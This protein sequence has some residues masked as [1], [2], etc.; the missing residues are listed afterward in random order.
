MKLKLVGLSSSPKKR[1]TYKLIEIALQSAKDAVLKEKNDIEVEIEIV[2]LAGKKITGCIDC[3]ACKKRGTFCV[4]KDDWYKCVK[5]LIDPIPDGVIIG[6]PVYF[7]STNSILRAFF[8]RCTSLFKKASYK[9]NPFEIPDWTKPLNKDFREIPDWTKTVAGAVTVGFHRNG[10]Q[11]HAAV[12]IINWLL[13][14][15]FIVVG[16]GPNGYIAG[17]AWSGWNSDNIENPPIMFDK[18]GLHSAKV[19]GDRVGET[20]LRIR[21]SDINLRKQEQNL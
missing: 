13:T 7:F 17:T 2:S 8:E 12:D 19:L 6:S 3:N 15:G 14:T 18:I 16:N 11:E 5:C 4:L 1:S 21:L 10:G 9:R 20:A